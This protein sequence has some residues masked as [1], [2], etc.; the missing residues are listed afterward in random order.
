MS[1]YFPP[2]K[3]RD[4]AENEP[5]GGGGGTHVQF[6]PGRPVEF[7]AEEQESQEEFRVSARQGEDMKNVAAAEL[8]VQDALEY[9]DQQ[10]VSMTNVGKPKNVAGWSSKWI[11]NGGGDAEQ[12]W[13]DSQENYSCLCKI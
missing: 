10:E 5:K 8:F 7:P 9:L 12:S 4:A 6:A 2:G 13:T 3:P 1:S 11:R